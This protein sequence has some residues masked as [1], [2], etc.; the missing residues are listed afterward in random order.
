MRHRKALLL[1]APL[2]LILLAWALPGEKV[3]F[4]PDAGQTVVKTFTTVVQLELEDMNMLVNGEAPPVDMSELTMEMGILQVVTVSDEYAAVGEGRPERL[5]RTYETISSDTSITQ[6]FPMA[7]IDMD[8]TIGSQSELEG[9]M[10]IFEWDEEE[11]ELVPSFEDE[12]TDEELLEDLNEDMD[13]RALLPSD[14]VSEGD[15]WDIDLEEL[16]RILAAGGDL[17]IVPNEDDMPDMGGMSGMQGMS[18]MSS[19]NQ[20]VGDLEGTATA[21]FSGIEEVDGARVAVIEI[22]IEVTSSQ[23][24]TE[25]VR[26]Q[27]EGLEPP[28]GMPPMDIEVGFMDLEF[29]LEARGILHWNQAAGVVHSFE[30][31]GTSGIVMDMGQT[32]D[33]GE[34][35]L[36]L[37]ISFEMAGDYAVTVTAEVE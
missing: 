23:D 15:T 3:S 31:K 17:K 1:G 4:H 5:K 35:V 14:E 21:E 26:E 2:A 11:G 37:E 19:A 12:E 34:R 22:E 32:I 30:M 16:G 27:M 9:Q 20:F 25:E 24:L 8:E 10:V 28:E 33:M 6:Q 36:E 13:L 29:A 18:G 7:G